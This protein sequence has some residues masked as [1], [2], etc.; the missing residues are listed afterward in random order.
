MGLPDEFE[1][2][3]PFEREDD[4]ER[5]V[6][7]DLVRAI[8]RSPLSTYRTAFSADMPAIYDRPRSN[9]GVERPAI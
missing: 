7:D 2:R 1:V 5:A 9:A 4:V 8:W 6:S 3:A